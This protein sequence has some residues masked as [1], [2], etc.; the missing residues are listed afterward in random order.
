MIRYLK[1]KSKFCFFSGLAGVLI[2]LW[3]IAFSRAYNGVH[4]WDQ[5][6]NGFVVGLLVALFLTCDP[7]YEYLSHLRSVI[8]PYPL[9]SDRPYQIM[10]PSANHTLLNY[11]T[12]SF[13]AL[14]VIG[15][16]FFIQAEEDGIPESWTDNIAH[17]CSK[18]QKKGSSLTTVQQTYGKLIYTLAFVGIY[19][20]C[21]IE[22]RLFNNNYP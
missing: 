10:L 11:L 20:G 13:F 7:V 1:V 4:S 21:V 16:I 14:H 9:I 5:L 22:S 18:G 15:L 6:L 3:I 2:L 17:A 19:L 12:M 8:M